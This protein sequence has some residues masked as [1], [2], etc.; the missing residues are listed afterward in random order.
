[1]NA[2]DMSDLEFARSMVDFFGPRRAAALVG[3][4]A[5]WS[6]MGIRSAKDM[7]SDSVTWYRAMADLRR[8]RDHLSA[9]GRAPASTDDLASWVHDRVLAA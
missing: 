8:F 1:M 4:C 6:V 5:L 3:Y 2:D 9:L 7:T